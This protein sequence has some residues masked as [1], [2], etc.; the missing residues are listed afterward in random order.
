MRGP[1]LRDLVCVGVAALSLAA[2]GTVAQDVPVERAGAPREEELVVIPLNWRDTYPFSVRFADT[3]GAEHV[4]DLSAVRFATDSLV[5]LSGKKTF[6]EP[7]LG[8]FPPSQVR[9]ASAAGQ[10]DLFIVQATD[11]TAQITL[12]RWL[13]RARIPILGY[14][15]RDAYL[16]RLDE[17][18]LSLAAAQETV[19]WIGL[20][21]PAYR[22][23]PDLDF[24]LDADPAHRLKLRLRLDP[25]TYASK[26]EVLAALGK[27]ADAAVV[28][29]TRTR[30]DWI[31]RVD[32][33]VAL[34]H[35]FAVQP[36]C[37]WVERFVDFQLD[38]NVARTSTS[39]PTGRGA[40]AG[41]IMDVEDVWARGIRGEGQIASASDTGLSTGDITTPGSLHWDFGQV[42]SGTNPM[43]V[44]K[45]YA[46]GRA[47]WD[48]PVPAPLNGG[49]GTHTSGSIV[50]NGIRSGSTPS[51][52]TF[53]TSSFAG[54]APKAGFV[55]QS[56]LD[57]GGGLGGIP[58]DLNTLFQQTY[59]DGARVHSN[60][61]GAPSAGAYDTNSENLDEFAWNR[62]DM[63]ITF[64]AGN[65][66]VDSST[67]DGVINTDS[68][69]SPGTAKNCITVGASENH[70]PDF[71]YEY[72]SG[73]C[74][75]DAYNQA[76]WGW[77]NATNFPVAPIRTDPMADNANGMGAFSSRGPTDDL[78]FKPDITAPGIAIISTRSNQNQA[79]EQWGTCNV[80]V[81]QQTH[82]LAMGG[83]SMAN[84]LTAGTATLVRQ[85]YADG[86]HANGSDVTNTTPV[87]A[88]GFNP[89]SALVKATLI[90]G[91]WD[92]AP[93][94]YGSTSPQPEI[95]P[96]W[97]RAANR[98]LP[99]NAE[100]Y[101]RVDLEASLFPA[102][103]WGRS[104]SRSMYVRDVA[105]GIGTGARSSYSFGVGLGSDPFI[106]TL[107]WTDPYAT[108]GTGT[109][110]VNN[111]D[112]EVTSPSGR[113][114]TT[115]RLDAY[116]TAP[117]DFVRDTRNN[118]EQVKVTMPETG[119]WTIDVVGTSVP[120]NAVG[121]T[122]SQ[123][124]ALV[125][126]AVSCAVPAAAP[127]GV[128]AVANGN[129]RIDVSWNSTG[130]SEYHVYRGTASG[131]A[132][133]LVGTGT[134]PPFMDTTVVAGFTYYYVVKAASGPAC[135]SVTSAEA[136]ATATGVCSLGP[137]FA[138][139][140]SVTSSS[141]G[142]C[143]LD[144][145]WA[146]A[147]A[148]CGGPVS[149][150]VYRSTTSGFT[151]GLANR[152][153]AGLATTS[154]TDSSG[155]AQGTT[156]YYVVRATDE[157]NGV[158]EANTIQRSGTPT[159]LPSN[160]Y[161][162]GR[163]TFDAFTDG[164]YAGWALGYFT[165]DAVD[166]RGVRTCTAQSGAKVFRFGGVGCTDDYAISKHSLARPPGIAVPAGA[167]NV[168]LSF[169]HRWAFETNWD[170]A[171]L[172]VSLDGTTYTVV[173][174][175]P[176]LQGPYNGTAGGRSSWT[177]TQGTFVN[178]IVDLDAACNLIAGNT[179]GCAGKTVYIGFT[180]YSDNSNTL[181]GW[182]ID[183]VQVTADVP[184]SCSAA[185]SPASFL[186]ARSTSG[187]NLL[188][189]QNPASGAYG[190]AEVR[191]RT[192]GI[193]PTSASDGTG[194]TCSGQNA[195]LGAYNSCSHAAVNGTTYHY[196]LFVNNGSGVYSSRRTVA[197][198]P[199]VTTGPWKW[200][201]ST[202]AA[203]LAP[204]GILPGA[205]DA[206]G[207]FAVSNDR[208][209]HAMKPT[210]AGGSWPRS[211]SFTWTPV[212]MNGPAQ[213]RPPV[214]P[215]AAGPRVFLASQDGYAYAVNAY[216]GAL[217]W[218]S[219]KLGDVLQASPAGLFSDLR[220]GAPDR[221]FFGTR[222]ATSANTL[223]AL[224]PADGT[225]K[226]QFD[227]GGGASAI[228]I[229]TGITVDYATSYVYFTSRA[230]G[231]GSS[232]TLWCLNA[233]GGTLS[234]VWSTA[235]G[236]IDGSPVLHL[237]K[238]YV[239]TNTGLVRKIDP[240]THAVVWT[241]TPAPLNGP[242]KGYVFPEFGSSP[243]RLYFATTDR[244]WAIV[245]NGTTAADGW[246]VTTVANPSTPLHVSGTTHLLVGSGNGTL[247]Q[248]ATSNGAVEGSVSLGT[249][250]L[251]SPARD[252]L[253]GRF[254]VGSTA[255]VLH[256]V[257]LPQP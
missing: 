39:V 75:G 84:P 28:D 157:G 6:R 166:W 4:I 246:S 200:A 61:W 177:N 38:N 13:E 58:A 218:T 59:D 243:L 244:V 219:P 73:D 72:P 100:G 16:V 64:S 90:N 250:A 210:D 214:V 129:N 77:F 224:D 208:V 159:G 247:Y 18:A 41:P 187:A 66:G 227:N 202:G 57:S 14:I 215:L 141:G 255:G 83:T 32:G 126:S 154:F 78:R 197:A 102:A 213:H 253:N 29:V 121:G 127:T 231:A 69:G 123:P 26:D 207:V 136:S 184:G 86:W 179:G 196:S 10:R 135:E 17:A 223:F 151:P 241:Y 54:T 165:G 153:A 96:N 186:T 8:S 55:F 7:E 3:E 34:A 110:L 242:V 20:F 137:T 130:A 104:A 46:L 139:L 99:N 37:L 256:T 216:N 142:S 63:V 82:Y 27:V 134:A 94:Q 171:Y 60:S 147:S 119:Q 237:G 106:A 19:F 5:S 138:G 92:M 193:F 206:G 85:Y 245:D 178:T 62:K 174:A 68:I 235:V 35:A 198:M 87:P 172:R 117:T 236:D 180:A 50:G 70:R 43:R 140:V 221:V 81:A 67:T 169:Y 144:L 93:G 79:Y 23:A 9:P 176:L 168:R 11:P 162:Y 160:Q 95:P 182:F 24:I 155:L 36:G 220:P 76:A 146:A 116:V 120:G 25:E 148:A 74:V 190:S 161:L 226:A 257:A 42:G 192:D 101:G 128:A 105:S 222:N 97:D 252:S 170:G 30:R 229:I 33:P 251:G 225:V 149:Y 91:A 173:T 194:V 156:Y 47:T 118:V 53:P 152:I 150:S 44:L 31:V 131:G 40:A 111:L 163:E 49:H 201:Y 232:D 164:N 145:N 248:L 133:S 107:V 109:K 188:E 51:T 238:L 115:N 203:S 89:S 158:Q 112:L 65:S 21:Q 199:N 211:G 167:S 212:A 124:F 103:G 22:V 2:T 80:P 195:A 12:R 125:L 228:G 189:W 204:A 52:N 239:G 15:P 209:I 191:F 183:D 233:T 175:A 254:H 48:D 113:R 88:Q 56:V 1:T 132:T 98:D 143:G 240:T 234:K 114:Y 185:P 122:T 249:S 71:I 217:L 45:G 230:A 181:D 205:L 108:A